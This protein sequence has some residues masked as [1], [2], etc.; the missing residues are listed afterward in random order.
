VTPREFHSRLLRRAR[1]AGVAITP[2][3][4]SRL[5]AYYRVLQL[6]NRKI[7]LTGLPLDEAS[8][9]TLDRLLVEPLVA[10]RYIPS[11]AAKLIDLGS[12]GGSPA[13]PTKI[14]LPHMALTMVEVKTRKSAFLRE[15]VRQLQL[16]NAT[17][18]TARFEELLPRPELHE[19]MDVA[20]I[21]AV[22]IEARLLTTIQAFLKPSGTLL[23]FKSAGS[24]KPVLAPPLE[25]IGTHSLVESIGS[26]LAVLRKAPLP[27]SMASV[28]RGT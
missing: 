6:W 9:E 19:A 13:I 5:E 10:A 12:G 8:D 15:V 25:W 11:D 3:V 23:L 22:R 2:D 17:V 21:R 16:D 18:E 14:V 27:S 26:R 7:N 4:A 28:P 24:D 20:T 1:K